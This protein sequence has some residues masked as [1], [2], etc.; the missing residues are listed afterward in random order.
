MNVDDVLHSA[1]KPADYVGDVVQ[2]VSWCFVHR[3]EESLLEG[4]SGFEKNMSCFEKILLFK[5]DTDIR[6]NNVLPF[7]PFGSSLVAPGGILLIHLCN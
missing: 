3:M 7:F 5:M 6:E 4:V 1:L 2:R